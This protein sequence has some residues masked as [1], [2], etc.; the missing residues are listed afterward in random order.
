MAQIRF[1]QHLNENDSKFQKVTT[2]DFIDNSEGFIMYYFKDGSKCNKQYIA[3]VNSDSIQGFEFAEVSS[4]NNIWKLSKFEP[5]VI[6]EKPKA[7]KADNGILYEAPDFSDYIGVNKHAKTRV[8]VNSKPIHVDN[9][10]VP[11]D[12]EY[13]YDY[14]AAQSNKD[15]TKTF[16]FNDNTGNVNIQKVIEK[17]D[18]PSNQNSDFNKKEFHIDVNWL[19]NECEKVIIDFPDNKQ[20]ELNPTE[21]IENA[22]TPKEEKVVEKV[23]EKE[24]IVKS[25]DTDIDLGVD[26]TQKALLDNMID[27]SNK[28]ECTFDMELTL[29]LP[30]TSVYKLIKTV[31]P[32]G[33]DRGF[34][35]I[36]ANRMQI[37]ELKTSVAEGLQ[38]FYEEDIDVIADE[39]IE[40]K[41]GKQE[42]KKSSHK[43]SSSK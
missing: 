43:K 9:F 29:S 34:V 12:S 37:K 10:T 30:P 38:A 31:Y 23:V 5:A 7:I 1:F 4:Q 2:L 39:T 32:E 16:D 15:T 41:E 3:P 19:L 13:Y 27:M 33:M 14:T 21:F 28:E 36:L 17:Q 8:I 35:N 22:I 26:T 20:L 25:S 40:P 6:L 24:V 11:D 42:N 18:I